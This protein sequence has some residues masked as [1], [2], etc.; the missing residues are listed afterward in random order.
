MAHSK[1]ANICAELIKEAN[2]VYALTGAGISTSA[3]I[4][5][6]RGP[7]GLYVTKKYDPDTV[8]DI[9]WFLRDPK[10]FYDF[11]RDFVQLTKES[12]P[13]FTHRFLEKLEADGKL[14][15]IVT[16]NIDT[17]H[18][19]AGSKNLIELHGS[20][21]TSHCLS[22]HREYPFELMKLKVLNEEIPT[23]DCGGLIKPDVVFFGENV[24]GIQEALDWARKA[25]LFLVIGTSC[26]V[27]PAAM[28]PSYC[29]GK[30]IVVN[31]GEM[32]IKFNN[33][34]LHVQDDLDKFFKEVSDLLEGRREE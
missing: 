23:C 2:D 19:Q 29:P 15:G 8:F 34:I 24:F 16:Q 11:A 5:D 20:F 13:T 3:G 27:Y 26:V 32:G 25:D 4:P 10:P 33:M 18:T 1:E 14:Q 7:Q 9:S 28:I 30:I 6:F 22:C 21:W 12:Q 31:K 17:L